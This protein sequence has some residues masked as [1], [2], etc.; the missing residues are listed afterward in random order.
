MQLNISDYPK[1]QEAQVRVK[2]AQ[3]NL[4]KALEDMNSILQKGVTFPKKEL[5]KN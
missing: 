4:T 2:I 1:L 5:T 3:E